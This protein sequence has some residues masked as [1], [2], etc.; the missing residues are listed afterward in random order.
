MP[1]VYTLR[2]IENRGTVEGSLALRGSIKTASD[3]TNDYKDLQDIY[4]EQVKDF[5]QKDHHL[6][7]ANARLEKA[8][9]EKDSLLHEAN[10]RIKKYLASFEKKT[11][12]DS[13]EI[14]QVIG[15][16]DIFNTTL[17]LPHLRFITGSEAE[18]PKDRTTSYET[19]SFGYG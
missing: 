3:I 7:D 16:T 11:S 18:E 9:S 14:S 17:A 4:L 8:L 5:N 13:F 19:S 2:D 10:T 15:G 6:Q 1:N 12:P